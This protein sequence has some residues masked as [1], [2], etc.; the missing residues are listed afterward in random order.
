MPLGRRHEVAMSVH[1]ATR[2]VRRA[3]GDVK[4]IIKEIGRSGKHQGER[5]YFRAK[6]RDGSQTIIWGRQ[7]RTTLIHNRPIDD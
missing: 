7:R 2:S 6:N 5:V 1:D 3:V 4:R